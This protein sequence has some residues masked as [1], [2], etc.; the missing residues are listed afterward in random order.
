M[1]CEKYKHFVNFLHQNCIY[2]W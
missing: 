1:I 2:H